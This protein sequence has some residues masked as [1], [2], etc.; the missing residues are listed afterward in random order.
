[1]P[2]TSQ[3]QRLST[4]IAVVIELIETEGYDAVQV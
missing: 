2:A 4:V 3:D 1:M